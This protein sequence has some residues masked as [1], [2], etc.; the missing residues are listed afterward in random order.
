MAVT[1]EELQYSQRDNSEIKGLKSRELK[2]NSWVDVCLFKHTNTYTVVGESHHRPPPWRHCQELSTRRWCWSWTRWLS[3]GERRAERERRWSGEKSHIWTDAPLTRGQTG[4]PLRSSARNS[5][6]LIY[7]AAERAPPGPGSAADGRL[8][9]IRSPA[10]L[11]PAALPHR[12]AQ[13]RKLVKTLDP[14]PKALIRNVIAVCW[15]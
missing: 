11:S 12:L 13:W 3:A 8:L 15:R 6:E 10:T 7:W 1:E 5:D 9:L 14:V 4:L 2:K